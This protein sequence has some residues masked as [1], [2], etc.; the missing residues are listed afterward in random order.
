[1]LIFIILRFS[2]GLSCQEVGWKITPLGNTLVSTAAFLG[3]LCGS[4]SLSRFADDYGRRP[5]YLVASALV[6]V[7]GLGSAV[8][9]SYVGEAFGLIHLEHHVP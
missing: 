9:H 8:A 1:M 5:S 2:Y 6:A 7:F 3:M 4:L